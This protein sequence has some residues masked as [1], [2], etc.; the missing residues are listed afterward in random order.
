MLASS[1]LANENKCHDDD[2][3][4]LFQFQA[5]LFR[6]EFPTNPDLSMEESAQK[7]REDMLKYGAL[8]KSEDGKFT[9]ANQEFLIELSSITQNFI[10]SYLLTLKGCYSFRSRDIS[11][12]DLPT[13]IQEFGKARLA[14]NEVQRPESLSVANLKNAIRAFREEG[15]LQIR[16]DGS[17]ITFDEDVY[18]AYSEDLNRLLL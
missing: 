17:G 4:R 14:I 8:E 12:K 1:I 13:K 5:F 15:V 18:T 9:V 10:E 7:S 11:Q 16:V 3:L 2:T 6:Y